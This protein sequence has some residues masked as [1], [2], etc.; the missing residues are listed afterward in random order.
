MGHRNKLC[1]ARIC[2]RVVEQA[3]QFHCQI[4]METSVKLVDHQHSAFFESADDR[5]R[6]CEEPLRA[7]RLMAFEIKCNAVN[8]SFLSIEVL[9]VGVD[10]DALHCFA[11]EEF[12]EKREP[13]LREEFWQV[14]K[15]VSCQGKTLHLQALDA[16]I[17]TPDEFF[18]CPAMRRGLKTGERKNHIAPI[19]HTG[20]DV[21]SGEPFR[22]MPG[23]SAVELRNHG[24]KK[25]V[26]SGTKFEITPFTERARIDPDLLPVAHKKRRLTRFSESV[27]PFFDV[28]TAAGSVT[29]GLRAFAIVQKGDG[30][31]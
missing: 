29:S 25:R 2:G 6:Q 11:G 3:D 24:K 21:E 10:A 30:V 19:R 23:N 12:I 16:G 26:G 18:D 27:Q 31:L 15:Y 1:V 17:E 28:I 13:C 5:V 8:R 9:M 20:I 4:R 14:I 7:C 22:Q